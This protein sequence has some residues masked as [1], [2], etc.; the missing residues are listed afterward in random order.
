MKSR[1]AF[2]EIDAE[3]ASGHPFRSH[4]FRSRAPQ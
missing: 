2:P 3:R 4:P 1:R